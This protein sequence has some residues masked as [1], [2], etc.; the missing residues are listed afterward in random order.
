MA[1]DVTV[2][3]PIGFSHQ[4][5]RRRP[6][7][8][9]SPVHRFNPYRVFSS[10]ET[11]SRRANGIDNPGFNPYR[12]FSSA[13][14]AGYRLQARHRVR[15]NPYRVFS[16]AETRCGGALSADILRVSIPIGFSHQ[17]RPCPLWDRIRSGSVS[18]PI[19]F[20]H[21]LRPDFR[22]RDELEL[23][24]SIP[25]GFS[26]QLRPKP[27][28]QSSLSTSFNPYRV[29]SSAETVSTHHRQDAGGW[30]QSLSGF[31]IS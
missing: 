8:R 2:S 9:P 7:R 11:R 29:F 14:T 22:A 15:F 30:F 18:I 3:I 1:C 13:E 31:L 17:L 4:L 19:G 12:V 28:R 21:Q 25:I 10:A 6:C 26:H 16:S 5:R 20:S 23:L 24:V 27:R